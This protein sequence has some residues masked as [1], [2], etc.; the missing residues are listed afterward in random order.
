MN[1]F[2]RISAIIIMIDCAIAG[3]VSFFY[4]FVGF[5]YSELVGFLCLLAST[6]AFSLVAFVYSLAFNIPDEVYGLAQKIN[7]LRN[8]LESLKKA[9]SF[10]E[11]VEANKSS[12]DEEKKSSTVQDVPGK[13]KIS[14]LVEDAWRC[15]V[16]GSVNL[17]S[18]KNCFSCGKPCPNR[19][20][21]EEEKEWND[22][23]S[24]FF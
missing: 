8:E 18:Q 19:Q 13:K 12:E 14:K 6:L 23:K 9:K 3:L 5:S 24:L 7:T 1:G 2:A 20:S 17:A 16:C 10:E 21:S 4:A 22:T 11:N 15:P